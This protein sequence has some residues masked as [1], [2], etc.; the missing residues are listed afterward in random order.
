MV[1]KQLLQMKMQWRLLSDCWCITFFVF[2]GLASVFFYAHQSLSS[3]TRTCRMLNTNMLLED[4]LNELELAGARVVSPIK[5]IYSATFGF[6]TK[7]LSVRVIAER[8]KIQE[9]SIFEGSKKYSLSEYV[10]YPHGKSSILRS[11]ASS[12]FLAFVIVSPLIWSCCFARDKESRVFK[13][14]A[15]GLFVIISFLLFQKVGIL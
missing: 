15:E 9:I 13:Y 4:C 2:I 11:V 10:Q 5:G 14:M 12:L 6:P 7:R 1:R 3:R 8:E